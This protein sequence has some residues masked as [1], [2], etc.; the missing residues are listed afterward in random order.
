MT[1]PGMSPTEWLEWRRGGVG[2]SDVAAAYANVYGG[3][4]KAVGS[5]IGIVVDNIDETAADRGHRWEHRLADGIQDHTGL[6]VGGEQLWLEHGNN[7]RHRS[8]P[9]GFLFTDPHP[10]SV[11]EA[12]AG[13]E[14]K[15]RHPGAVWQWTYWTT[16]CQWHMHVAGL[17]RWLLVVATLEP[18]YD[19]VT[20]DLDPEHLTSVRYQWVYADSFLQDQLVT[21]AD[22]LLELID[23]NTMPDPEDAQALAYVKETHR[24]ADPDHTPDLDDIQE[25]LGR[26]SALKAAARDAKEELGAAEAR[27]RHVMGPATEAHTTDRTWRVRIGAPVRKFTDESEK[28]FIAEHCLHD[29]DCPPGCTVHRPDL[30]E[31]RLYLDMA[32]DEM[33]D[34]YEDHRLPTNDRRMTIAHFDKENPPD[35]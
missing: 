21:I 32:R 28:A 22:W 13:T 1:A 17:H 7:R 5:R 30:L 25:L 29:D 15:V 9:D 19:P 11:D 24:I 8:T 12:V 16:Q 14:I 23:T 31:A 35:E 27:I 18:H 6:Y 34:E 26:W 4:S 2:S 10:G 33:P 20:G 3:A